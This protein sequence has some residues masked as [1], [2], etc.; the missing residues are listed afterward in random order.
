MRKSKAES[1]LW[2]MHQVHLQQPCLQWAF[3]GSV[4]LQSVQ[5]EGSALLDQVV[6]HEHIHNL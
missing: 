1:D 3:S 4:V 6:L 2:R 5:Q